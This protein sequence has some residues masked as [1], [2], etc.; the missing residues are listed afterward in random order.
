MI[1]EKIAIISCIIWHK[2]FERTIE[3]NAAAKWRKY[4]EMRKV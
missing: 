3:Y 4:K 1:L 2:A